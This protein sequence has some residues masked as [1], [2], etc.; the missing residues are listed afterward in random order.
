MGKR[1]EVGSA[2]IAARPAEIFKPCETN[3]RREMARADDRLGFWDEA[4]ETL[5]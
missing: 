3:S 1:A 5:E 4:P 2:D